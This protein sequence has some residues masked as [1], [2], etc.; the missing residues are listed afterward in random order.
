MGSNEPEYTSVTRAKKKKKNTHTD[1]TQDRE[2]KVV[3]PKPEGRL[4][5]EKNSARPKHINHKEELRGH[6]GG[7]SQLEASPKESNGFG[8]PRINSGTAPST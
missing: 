8:P 7:T 2:E 4:T 5:D 6:A 3:T 1:T